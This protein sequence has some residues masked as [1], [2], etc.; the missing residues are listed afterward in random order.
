MR[1]PS[2]LPQDFNPRTP[3]GVRPFNN[4][5]DIVGAID[6]NPRTPRGVRRNTRQQDARHPKF[7]STHPARGAT[8]FCRAAV[9]P[10]LFQSTHPAR[11]ATQVRDQHWS[12][13]RISI[14]APREG[15]DPATGGGSH[16]GDDFNP[17][18]PRGVRLGNELVELSRLEFQSTHP[19]RGAT[20]GQLSTSSP[21]SISIHAPREGCDPSLKHRHPPY[22]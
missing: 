22:A 10:E 12:Y 8:T 19:A 2:H 6:F 21:M 9:S 4:I 17:R 3:R 16:L 1:Q 11:G 5:G 14:H 15:C 7:Q 18:T 13:P 20:V